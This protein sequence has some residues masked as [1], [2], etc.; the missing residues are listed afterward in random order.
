MP[1]NMTIDTTL[2]DPTAHKAIVDAI[3]P[4]MEKAEIPTLEMHDSKSRA[5]WTYNVQLGA[6]K[7]AETDP[8]ATPAPGGAAPGTPAAPAAEQPLQQ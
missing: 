7:P 2:Q 5:T 8:F 3:K 1:V 6:A 4:Y